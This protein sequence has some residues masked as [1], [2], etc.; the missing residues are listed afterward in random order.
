MNRNIAYDIMR[1]VAILLVATQHA[2]SML[3]FDTPEHG[4]LC[5]AYRAIV[6]AGVPLFVLIS[7]AL[8]L[9]ETPT[10]L[11][12]FFRKR[13]T[14]VLVPFLIWGMVVYVV[15]CLA[16]QYADIHTVKDAIVCFIPYL[17]QNKINDFHWFVHMILALYFLTPVLQRALHN[18]PS[19]MWLY[20]IGLWLAVMILRQ[21]YPNLF[22][23][24]YTS[25]I[26][27]YL[28]LYI[29][30][31]Y[32]VQHNV[33]HQYAYGLVAVVMFYTINVLSHTAWPF[34]TQLTAVALFVTFSSCSGLNHSHCFARMSTAVSRYSYLI[35]LIHIPVIRALYLC[36]DKME[37]TAVKTATMT[38]VIVAIVV[39]S[40]ISVGCLILD[41]VPGRFKHVLGVA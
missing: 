30:G 35:Y 1:M 28:G 29:F 22:I 12:V 4:M 11:S 6:D 27:S 20:L 40:L 36:F 24:K 21:V 38:P 34:L 17:L 26:V 15:S 7:G 8:L 23:L 10:S 13:F 9:N 31:G 25:S 41:T 39:V 37:W 14:R 19:S 18:Q 16:H 33:R 5:Y 3:G 2:W 32:W